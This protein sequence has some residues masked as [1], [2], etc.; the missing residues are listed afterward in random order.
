M[1]VANLRYWSTVARQVRRELRRWDARACQ[2]GDPVLRG[3]ARSKLD[4]ERFNAEVAATL[5][6]LAPRR[7]RRQA[8]AAT[9]AFQVMYD[10]LD[11]V[12][13]QPVADPLRNGHQLYRAFSDALSDADCAEDGYYVH[14]PQSDDGGYLRAL[15]TVC[16]AAFHSLP[17]AAAVAP[18]A[19]RTAIRCGEAQTRTHALPREGLAQ[20]AAWAAAEAEGTELTWWELAAGAAASVLSIHALIAAAAHPRTTR[21]EAVRVDAAYLPISALTTL[22]D[23][24]IDHDH[25]VVTG[26]HSFV[27][28]YASA[29]AAA[30]RVGAVARHG[31]AAAATL[32]HAPHHV[33]TVA[34]AAAYYLS[35]PEAG[36]AFARPIAARVLGELEPLV[37]PI[38][39]IFRLWRLAKRVRRGILRRQRESGWAWD[40][41]PTSTDSS[42]IRP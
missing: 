18:V 27:T 28:Y 4:E 33:M 6:T 16:R 26:E 20:L 25:D 2:I 30:E 11:A 29:R 19:Q 36:T 41:S 5:A 38:M 32:R 23:S 9:V 17:S 24:V 42:R 15:V 34:G 31:T 3:H 35:A 13:E 12:G 8:V 7:H 14:H 1:G 37:A 40:P 22:L 21:A 39:G 10:Y